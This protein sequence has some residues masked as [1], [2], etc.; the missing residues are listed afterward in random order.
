LKPYDYDVY[1]WQLVN[2][3]DKFNRQHLIEKNENTKKDLQTSPP[4]KKEKPVLKANYK[5]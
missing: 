5:N 2:V 4:T 1:A 3:D